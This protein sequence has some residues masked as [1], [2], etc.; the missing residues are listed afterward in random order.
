MVEAEKVRS[1]GPPVVICALAITR[2]SMSLQ[3]LIFSPAN[4]I[5]HKM[6]LTRQ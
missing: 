4:L 1:P 2:M 3:S 5:A 6:D